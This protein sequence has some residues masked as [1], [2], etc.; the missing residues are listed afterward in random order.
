MF[1]I[2]W[3][4]TELSNSGMAKP[5]NAL[6]WQTPRHCSPGISAFTEQ[7]VLRELTIYW[8]QM[9]CGKS[10]TILILLSYMTKCMSTWCSSMQGTAASQDCDCFG[11]G[12]CGH[13]IIIAWT[14]T[15]LNICRTSQIKILKCGIQQWTLQRV[16]IEF[17]SALEEKQSNILYQ[18]SSDSCKRRGIASL[19]FANTACTRYQSPKFSICKPVLIP[20]FY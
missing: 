3:A 11:P 10:R 18:V 19:V 9:L 2:V 16:L 15:P 7:G 17:C 8:C 13:L 14:W 4:N 6:M 1:F 5:V 20:W 12:Q